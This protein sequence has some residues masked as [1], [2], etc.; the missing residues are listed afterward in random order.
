MGEIKTSD[1]AALSVEE[2]L[3][4]IERVWDTLCETPEKILVPAWHIDAIDRA[5]EAHESDPDAGAAWDEVKQRIS[6]RS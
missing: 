3:D 1:I 2:R 4:L 5:V 6:D